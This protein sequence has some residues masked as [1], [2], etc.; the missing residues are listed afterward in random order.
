MAW[1]ELHQSLSTHRKIIRL[2]SLLKIE[3]PHAMGLVCN[4]WLW[5]V[6]NAPDGDLTAFSAE[7]IA[8]VCGYKG[9]PKA[10]LK[11]LVE[12]GFIDKKGKKKIIHDWADYTGKLMEVRE[13]R[14]Q[15]A[16]T[17]QARRRAKLKETTSEEEI[18][19]C[20]EPPE[21]D[22]TQS[23]ACV[24]RDNS[25]SHAHIQYSTVPNNISGG[26]DTCVR[27]REETQNGYPVED[28][29]D[30]CPENIYQLNQL[31]NELYQIPE[32]V[33]ERFYQ[34]VDK[35]FN[36][37]WK[38]GP[39]EYEYAQVYSLM[40]WLRYSKAAGWQELKMSADDVELLS[41]AVE[42]AA[43]ANKCFISYLRGIYKNFK[44]RNILTNDDLINYELAREGVG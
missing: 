22:V 35:L 30:D 8:E 39:T 36:A 17:R 14:K 2:K 19:E 6:D 20:S 31:A 13:I 32:T 25:V 28:D 37:F 40:R 43:K 1:I 41:Y 9:E 3:A 42:T 33:R 7:E 26:D 44:T 34:T 16:R 24:T 38:R 21:D 15:Q 12:V 23:H 29:I 4:L 11:K 18:S 27:A 5:A 10:F